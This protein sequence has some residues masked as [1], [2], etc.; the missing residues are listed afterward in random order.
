MM[1]HSR[2]VVGLLVRVV[3]CQLWMWR[4]IRAVASVLLRSPVIFSA[5]PA[6]RALWAAL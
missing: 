4:L 1:Q 2:L 3:M 6:V 5:C